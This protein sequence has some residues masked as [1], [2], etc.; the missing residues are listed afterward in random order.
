M[1]IA[2]KREISNFLFKFKARASLIGGVDFVPRDKNL[3]AIAEFGLTIDDVEKIVLELTPEHYHNGPEAD[4]DGSGDNVW[5]FGYHLENEEIY[6]KLSDSESFGRAK[7][8]SF[9]RSE[10][11]LTYPYRDKEE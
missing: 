8:L 3:N 4:Y 9:H 6:I 1:T 7:C 11:R 10:R 5:I 2:D